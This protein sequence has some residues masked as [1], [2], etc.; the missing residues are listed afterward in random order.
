MSLVKQGSEI[1]IDRDDEMNPYDVNQMHLMP[2]PWGQSVTRASASKLADG[3][4]ACVLMN[5]EGLM[6]L[7]YHT[8]IFHK[9][10]LDNS[11]F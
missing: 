1:V 2:T 10:Q 8:S 9:C 5:N 3:A 6:R 11:H 7:V 4:A